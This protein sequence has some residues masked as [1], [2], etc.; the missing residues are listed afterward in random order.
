MK[1]GP[2]LIAILAVAGALSLAALYLIVWPEGNGLGPSGV[3]ATPEGAALS[4]YM[5]EKAPLPDAG[6]ENGKGE[7]LT[8]KAFQGRTVL[9]NLWATWCAPCREEMPS[10]DR[11]EAQYGGPGFVVVAVS[12]DRNGIDLARNFLAETKIR[13]LALYADPSSKMMF[14]LKAFGLP[15]TLLISPQGEIVGRF[16]GPVNW[17]ETDPRRIIEAALAAAKG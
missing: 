12:M 10:L 15:T 6:F 2:R 7:K 11:L 13:H 14:A 8:L 1:S 3:G 9:L 4:N 16:V 17:D 5:P